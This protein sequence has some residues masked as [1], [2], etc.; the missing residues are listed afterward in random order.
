MIHCQKCKTQNDPAQAVC[1]H[2]GAELLPARGIGSRLGTLLLLIVACGVLPAIPVYFIFRPETPNPILKWVGYFLIAGAVMGLMYAFYDSFRKTL[3]HERYTIRA[4]HHIKLDPQQAI[5]DFTKALELV[6]QEGRTPQELETD[7]TPLLKERAAIYKDL[8]MR[9]EMESDWNEIINLAPETGRVPLLRERAEI[10]KDLGMMPELESD[11]DKIIE[12]VPAE[13][14]VKTL[15]EQAVLYNKL[16]LVQKFRSTREEILT[17]LNPN[18]MTKIDL[19]NIN[20]TDPQIPRRLCV[21]CGSPI[22][23][24][25]KGTIEVSYYGKAKISY[26]FPLCDECD[27]GKNKEVNSA[28]KISDVKEMQVLSVPM[29]ES[30]S[31]NFVNPV[32]A[33]AFLSA[34]S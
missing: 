34:N 20:F 25:S 17:K 15:R 30:L 19:K 21:Y 14:R 11:W 7:R 9:Q 32:Y 22:T 16:N 26:Q 18:E 13:E 24:Q 31:L 5:A 12:L 4:R 28:V 27:E 29:V 1:S 33:K 23:R 3:I 6:P 10:H 8:G 2:C